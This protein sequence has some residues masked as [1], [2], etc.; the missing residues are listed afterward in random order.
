MDSTLEKIINLLN[1]RNISQKQFVI[2]MGFASS[3]FTEWKRG[4]NKSYI[5]HIQKIADYFSV[6]TDYLLGNSSS[7]T[8]TDE[9][10]ERLTSTDDR[11][12]VR[13]YGGDGTEYV[14]SPDKWDAVKQ[15]LDAMSEEKKGL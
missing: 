2:D 13:A 9:E 6:S 10:I 7:Y 14:F 8:L 12:H 15:I 5:K 11:V 1:S 4:R 3:T